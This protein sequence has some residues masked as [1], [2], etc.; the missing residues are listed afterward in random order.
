MQASPS[1][2]SALV[3]VTL[4]R[5][6]QTSD[7]RNHELING[8]CLKPFSLCNLLHSIG[9]LMHLAYLQNEDNNNSILKGLHEN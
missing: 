4:S 5:Q 2:T 7:Q 6:V 1:P 8:G 9:K 3:Y